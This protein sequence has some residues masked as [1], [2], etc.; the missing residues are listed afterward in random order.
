MFFLWLE[1]PLNRSY[2]SS[3]FPVL[4]SKI[5]KTMKYA[6]LQQIYEGLYLN[7]ILCDI[8]YLGWYVNIHTYIDWLCVHG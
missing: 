3:I 2:I 8:T 7:F 6:S 5:S 4:Q 1:F